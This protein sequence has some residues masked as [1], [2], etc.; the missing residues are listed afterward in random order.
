MTKNMKRRLNQ[1]LEEY[2]AN[3]LK[4]YH[5]RRNCEFNPTPSKMEELGAFLLWQSSLRMQLFQIYFA[6]IEY[7]KA[8]E[9][10][11]NEL[12]AI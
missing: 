4:C 12:Q 3:K 8:Q 10:H 9:G 6:A 5:L 7:K 11:Q 2:D 1:L